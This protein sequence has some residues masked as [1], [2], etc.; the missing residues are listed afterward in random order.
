MRRNKL[1]RA[2][3]TAVLA[4][5]LTG[6]LTGCFIREAD[7]LYAMPKP[8]RDYQALQARLS[9]VLDS[10]GEYA[11]PLT[12][13]LIQSVQLQDLDG[14]GKQEAI[15]FFR[16]PNE[17]K[18]MKIYIFRQR[19]S[20]YEQMAVVEGAGTAINA[21]EYAQLDNSGPLELVVSW[22]MSSNARSLGAYSIAPGQAEEILRTE[23]ESYRLADL[24]QDNLQ[25]LVVIR[26]PAEASDATPLG[27]PVAEIYDFDGVVQLASRAYLSRGVTAVAS[28]G[29]RAGNLVDR[30][31]ALFVVS[32]YGENSSGTITDILTYRGGELKNITFVEDPNQPGV[33][34]AGESWE[35]VRY[36]NQVSGTDINSDGIMELPQPVP[37]SEYRSGGAASSNVNFWL[38]RWRQFDAQGKA[39]TVFTTYHDTQNGWYFIL[40][41]SWGKNLVLSRADIPGGIERSVTFSHWEGGESGEPKPFLTIYKLTGSSRVRRAQMA[42][43]FVVFPTEGLEGAAEAN[44][45]YAAEFKEGWDCGLTEDE[46]RERFNLIKTDWSGN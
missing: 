39:N 21:V 32:G 36:Y 45:I 12:G 33:P 18:P 17:E 9:E 26:T 34:G 16:F 7:E 46:V 15:A 29:V 41:D 22:Q 35:T 37:L 30:V 8:P 1:G 24:D 20:E 23:Y 11:A 27:I 4:A 19:G 6:L 10:G 13:E 3:L 2:A 31:P 25:E 44:T 38:S 40:P 42:G 5:L 43:R 14:D 28:G